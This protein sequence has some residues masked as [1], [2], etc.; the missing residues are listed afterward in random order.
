MHGI[1]DCTQSLPGVPAPPEVPEAAADLC[2]IG[3]ETLSPNPIG[4]H[5]STQQTPKGSQT[6]Q[7]M[8]LVQTWATLGLL[9]ALI[10]PHWPLPMPGTPLRD[11]LSCW[12][13][14]ACREE[15]RAWLAGGAIYCIALKHANDH[16]LDTSRVANAGH[17]QCLQ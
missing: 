9:C 3:S 4:P 13:G 7:E 12:G 17:T 2:D 11:N 14:L 5:A 8:W 16:I 10:Q 6:T 15:K 1:E